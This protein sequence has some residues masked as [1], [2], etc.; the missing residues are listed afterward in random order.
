MSVIERIGI[1]ASDFEE[2]P[3]GSWQVIDLGSGHMVKRINV[4]PHSRLS[5]PTHAHR[6]E[7]RVAVEGIATCTV[8]Q[9]DPGWQGMPD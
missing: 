6:S 5:L 1:R 3:W 4:H 9:P 2:R 8:G 7:H